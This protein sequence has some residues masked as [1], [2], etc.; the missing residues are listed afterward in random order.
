MQV[1][2]VK[3]G[4]LVSVPGYE[5]KRIEAEAVVGFNEKP[6]LAL[7]HLQ[8]WVDKQL[9]LPEEAVA[10]AEKVA[11]LRKDVEGLLLNAQAAREQLRK[12]QRLQGILNGTEQ[13]YPGEFSFIRDVLGDVS[14]ANPEYWK[15]TP[16][17]PY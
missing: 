3:Y 17:K 12:Y 1:F 9:N 10:L 11:S 6:E 14:P 5:N 8:D 15:P 4:R 13:V 7:A 16:T 2:S